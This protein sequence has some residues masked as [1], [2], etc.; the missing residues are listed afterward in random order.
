[1]AAHAPLQSDDPHLSLALALVCG[2]IGGL[3]ARLLI[4]SLFGGRDRFSAFRRKHPI[5]FAAACG[6]AV[7]VIGILTQASAVGGGHAQAAVPLA[8]DGHRVTVT[9]SDESCRRR[10]DQLFARRS[11]AIK[12]FSNGSRSLSAIMFGPSEGARSGS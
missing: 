4:T 7:A 9:G 3:F 11:N 1:M 10:L 12:V 6:L 5:R 8:K 2:L